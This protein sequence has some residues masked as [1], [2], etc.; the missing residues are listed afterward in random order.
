MKDAGIWFLSLL[1]LILA[2][3]SPIYMNQIASISRSTT[4]QELH[5]MLGRSPEHSFALAQGN[6]TLEIKVYPMV[7]GSKPVLTY[8]PQGTIYS[9]VPTTDDYIFIFESNALLCWGFLTEIQRENDEFLN[10]VAVS[11]KLELVE[12]RKRSAF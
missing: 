12:L 11:I 4:Q 5:T 3:A 10:Q 2:C 6:R 7:T 9:E 1:S 8:T